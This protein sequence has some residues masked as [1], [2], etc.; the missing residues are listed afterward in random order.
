MTVK[1]IATINCLNALE[2]CTGAGCLKAYHDRT[3]FFARYEGEETELVAFMYCNGCRA[4][5]HD[6]PGMQEKI[7]RLISLG[8]DVVHVGV[9][10]KTSKDRC[11][12]II[13]ETLQICSDAGMEVVRGTHREQPRHGP[14]P[15]R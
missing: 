5:P 2:V 11:C 4:M 9:C 7:D 6:D 3:D 8:T 12:K 14:Q 15:R 10:T 1:K 13:E